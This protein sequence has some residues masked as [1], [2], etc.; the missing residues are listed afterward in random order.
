MARP[1]P[2]YVQPMDLY[3]MYSGAGQATG[4][5]IGA[6]GKGMEDIAVSQEE[7]NKLVNSADFINRL[8][9]DAQNDFG[10]TARELKRLPEDI[11]KEEAQEVITAFKIMRDANKNFRSRFQKHIADGEFAPPDV[12]QYFGGDMNDAKNFVALLDQKGK[13][14]EGVA[15]GAGL[16]AIGPGQ[17]TKTARAKAYAKG[18]G[19][20]GLQPGKL[21]QTAIAEGVSPA[22]KDAKDKA[23]A[24]RRFRISN[25]MHIRRKAALDNYHKLLQIGDAKAK[26]EYQK[27][28][29]LDYMLKNNLIPDDENEIDSFMEATTKRLRK[30]KGKEADRRIGAKMVFAKAAKDPIVKKYGQSAMKSALEK[31]IVGTE[32]KTL[33]EL[34]AAEGRENPYAVSPTEEEDKP[35]LGT[36]IIKWG[37]DK[38]G[39][40]D[41]PKKGSGRFK[42]KVKK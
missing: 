7:Y 4:K 11:T 27:F 39:I 25:T 6:I 34:F 14:L 32:F 37:K 2:P 13:E 10:L 29:T 35:G 21:G 16:A 12:M 5:A 18:T 40:G 3:G 42:V 38:L 23:A 41:K 19:V 15:R 17:E 24:A 22:D 8:F 31:A 33:D 30:D 20:A 28:E 1:R 36:Q 26:D 9:T